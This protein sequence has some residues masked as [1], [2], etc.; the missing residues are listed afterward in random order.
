MEIQWLLHSDK[1]VLADVIDHGLKIISIAFM[2]YF[3]NCV[4]GRNVVK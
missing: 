3:L 4:I 1:I 2:E